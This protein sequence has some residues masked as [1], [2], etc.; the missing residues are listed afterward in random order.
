MLN[1]LKLKISQIHSKSLILGSRH[2]F[3]SNFTIF[4]KTY[5]N[6]LMLQPC[7]LKIHR[8][9]PHF[10]PGEKFFILIL[11]PLDNY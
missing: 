2:S 4:E 1:M 7:K 5:L 8:N 9:V 11:H 3:L 10:R 6:W